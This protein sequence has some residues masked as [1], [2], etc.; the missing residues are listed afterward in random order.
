MILPTPKT[1]AN[2][3]RLDMKDARKVRK[4][5]E[6]RTRVSIPMGGTIIADWDLALHHATV[7]LNEIEGGKSYFDIE[8]IHGEHRNGY[9][10]E[11]RALYINSGDTYNATLLYDRD[12]RRVYCTTMGDFV[13]SLERKG[14]KIV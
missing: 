7:A 6:N 11:I 4:A 14:E 1:I 2:F 8:A 9:W 3:F 5:L 13:E 10:Q 12:T